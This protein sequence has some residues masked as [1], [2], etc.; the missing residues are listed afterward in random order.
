MFASKPPIL[1]IEL[2]YLGWFGGKWTVTLREGW[3]DH[4]CLLQARKPLLAPRIGQ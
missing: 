1:E 3:V 4:N 2:V